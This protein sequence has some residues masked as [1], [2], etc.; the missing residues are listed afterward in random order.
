MDLE[1][2]GFDLVG[3]LSLQVIFRRKAVFEADPSLPVPRDE[4]GR[5]TV[6]VDAKGVATRLVSPVGP[7]VRLEISREDVGEDA[8]VDLERTKA[9]AETM[10][11][12]HAATAY[13]KVLAD[14]AA[15]EAR[16]AEATAEIDA[17]RGELAAD[18]ER[19]AAARRG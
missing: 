4:K 11:L 15:F 10:A 13:A 16:I 7:A 17:K 18:L 14:P 9:R 2:L 1:L 12:D 3:G 19:V 8:W 6:A 5:P